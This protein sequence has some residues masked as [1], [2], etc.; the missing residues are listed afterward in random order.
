MT[1]KPT[2]IMTTIHYT[3]STRRP[4]ATARLGLGGLILLAAVM[5]GP[6]AQ[7]QD[8]S[9][10]LVLRWS[11]DETMGLV[12]NDAT[13]QGRH[14]TLV[15]CWDE[16]SHWVAGKTGN[17]VSFSLSVSN[18]LEV[19]NLPE[20][21][22]TTWS[23][24]VNL[25]T[26]V[27]YSAIM[28]SAY[29]GVPAGQAGH[30]MG[31][32][33]GGQALQP[34]VLW[35]HN[36]GLVTLLSP[37]P[38]TLQ[39]WHHVAVTV[40]AAS[41]N[42]VL[43]V[44]GEQAAA[45]TNAVARPFTTVNLARRE[46]TAAN[47][48]DGA[49]DEVRI[50]NRALSQVEVQE[51]A[52]W[53][54]TGPPVIV[55]Q[56][57]GGSTYAGRDF[58]LSVKNQGLPPFTYQWFRA[59]TAIEG[60]TN[61]TLV[62]TN[63]QPSQGGNYT[64]TVSNSAGNTPSQ[65]ATITVI[66]ITDISVGLQAWWKFDEKSGLTAMDSSGKNNH[67][68]LLNYLGD[69]TQWV[70]GQVNGALAFD[71]ILHTVEVPDAPSI[72]AN[73]TQG[74]SVSTWFNSAVA[75]STGG[76]T[77]RMFEKGD[78]IFLLQGNGQTN[79]LGIG[80]MNVNVKRGGT[81]NAATINQALVAGRWY[82][83]AG[84]FDGQVLRAYL[85][86]ELTGTKTVGGPID[87]DKLPLRIGS[88]DATSH[89]NGAMDDVRIWDR[90]LSDREIRNLVGR[91]LPNPPSF[92]LQPQGADKYAGTSISFSVVTRGQEP[93][94]YTWYKDGVAIT[95]ATNATLSLVRL[96]ASDA[97]VYRVKAKN[98]LGETESEAAL[99]TVIPITSIETGLQ[100][101]WKFDETSDFI[102]HDSTTNHNDGQLTDF[103]DPA[104][105]WV[106]GK[107][108]GALK[109]DGFGARVI[110]P[111]SDSLALGSDASFA[112]WI[113]P[114]TYG[115]VL[116]D[117]NFNYQQGFIVRKPGQYEAFVTDNPGNVRATVVAG[118]GNAPQNSLTT[119]QWQH[120]VA[121]RQAGTVQFYTNGFPAGLPLNAGIGA[122]NTNNLII[123]NYTEDLAAPRL[124]QGLI[125]E[126]GLWARPLTEGEVLAL[127]GKDA[128]GP[129]V[130]ELAP[131]PAV[132]L[133]GGTAELVVL[134][135][136]KRPVTY[137]WYRDG[138]PVPDSATNR[139]VLANLTVAQAGSYTVKIRNEMGET[140]SQPVIV[141]VQ[142]ILGTETGL[143][144]YWPFDETSGTTFNDATGRGHH[145]ALQNGTIVPGI[146][147]M[148]GGAYDFD[149]VDDFAIVP[150]SDEL[151]ITD[152]LTISAWVNPRTLSVMG[153]LSR[154]VRKD[155]NWDLS[156]NNSAALLFYGLN[157]A[158]YASPAVITT[159][160]WQ[161]VAVVVKNNT[162][163]F[164]RNG[165]SLAAPVT[166]Y[167]GPPNS[168]PVIIGNFQSNLDIIRLMNGPMD[169]LGIW[170]RALR[171]Q[172]IEGI[173]VN[174][175]AGKPLTATYKPLTIESLEPVGD[176]SWR[177]TVSTP[178]VQKTYAVEQTE[179]L[180]SPAVWTQ[181]S[182]IQWTDKGQ[183]IL[184][185]S[186]IGTN[187][188]TRFLRILVL[189]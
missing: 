60:A 179:S 82:H 99:L 128:S 150:H 76:N 129:P 14:G 73:L 174:G 137:E 58:T 87:D 65:P 26:A 2:S 121:V 175:L 36:Q 140:T 102:A 115:T 37:T 138:V 105:T 42:I 5:A 78:C 125:D 161:H 186:F 88:D 112:F 156:F 163:E 80:G 31:F 39:E 41:S 134:A 35:N 165:A 64:V 67:G 94:T 107:A 133:E 47:Y 34:R 92:I 8:I 11:M 95:N 146:A 111:H 56:P 181:M 25:T 72:G 117:P 182:D 127:A 52:G 66:A 154:I 68:T 4:G 180:T 38:L 43:Y 81:N 171:A 12:A 160:E 27:N 123:G 45:A 84:T 63:L 85:D 32:G 122:A 143:V 93:F 28:S 177:L 51:L 136:G 3:Q 77:Y 16:Y 148:V 168:V 116:I 86:G 13:G 172:E 83:L 15:N 145:G 69:D 106:A 155:I 59:G 159:N 162:I 53:V 22:S 149:G 130:V 57:A 157:K 126:L 124:Y 10:G 153:G 6:P 17:A 141:E 135:T 110:V 173:Y 24:W 71:G 46:A 91:D 18:Y 79:S 104:Q 144:A 139:L 55:Q 29:V 187:N 50:Y 113:N 164:F 21:T 74:F 54:V 132:R 103:W 185:T 169:D 147:G 151:S 118:G 119:N 30:S 9:Q 1:P 97:G 70:T 90:A 158:S 189:E 20:T 33:T 170:H 108:G 166:A 44:N 109:F 188:Q 178:Y 7:A 114:E 19:A 61:S 49:V 23:A 152:Q 183:G 142:P 100:A 131:E 40:D 89:F 167:L 48:L 96:Q 75:L 184:E 62:L 101:L 176:D 120:F 98:D